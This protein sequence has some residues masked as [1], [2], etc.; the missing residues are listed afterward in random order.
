MKGFILAASIL[1]GS[2]SAHMQMLKPYPIR[3]PLNK[4]AKGQKDYSYTNPLNPSGADYPCKGYAKDDFDSVATYQQGQQYTLELDGSATHSGGSCQISLSYDQGES[5]KVIES[6]L[7]VNV[8]RQTA[9]AEFMR[10]HLP[11]LVSTMGTFH[12]QLVRLT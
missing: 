2:A 7:R 4:E 8:F 1:A 10:E 5:F 3:S 11:G 9:Y 12:K 6:M